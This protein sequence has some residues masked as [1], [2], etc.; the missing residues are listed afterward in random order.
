[1]EVFTTH[2]TAKLLGVSLPTV[3]NWVK[4][5][6]LNA[7]RTPGGHRR[8]RRGDLHAF[9]VAYDLPVP[10]KLQ[11]DQNANHAPE[12]PS[13]VICSDDSDISE[14]I[15]DFLQIASPNQTIVADTPLEAG[16][17]L[18]RAQ[19]G[20]ALVDTGNFNA[21]PT[22]FVELLGPSFAL[23]I[24]AGSPEEAAGITRKAGSLSILCKPLEIEALREAVESALGSLR[25]HNP[26]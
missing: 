25:N 9:C 17:A 3:I 21:A 14:V 23:V 13:I 22:D 11:D 8:I 26:D 5:G 15:K 2:Q 7:Y 12:N 1:M 6:K 20:V 24:L 18:G 16:H 10:P 4:E 19:A